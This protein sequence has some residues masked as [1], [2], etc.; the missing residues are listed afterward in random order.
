MSIEGM[1]RMPQPAPDRNL[2]SQAHR[3]TSEL[4]EIREVV[5]A[6]ER[7]LSP[8]ESEAF[9]AIVDP[10]ISFDERAE[11][12]EAFNALNAGTPEEGESIADREHTSVPVNFAGTNLLVSRS[13]RGTFSISMPGN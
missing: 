8:Q 5:K 4:G 9:Y 7:T 11:R 12:I 2:E 6:I 10:A 3:E 13:Q 1:N